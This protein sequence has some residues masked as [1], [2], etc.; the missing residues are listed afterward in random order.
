M[1][2][3]KEPGEAAKFECACDCGGE[4]IL[5]GKKLSGRRSVKSCGC[6]FVKCTTPRPIAEGYEISPEGCWNWTGR[7]NW[8]GYG[9]RG[10]KKAHR[11]VYEELV[12][13]IPSGMDVHHKCE[14]KR[15]VNPEHLEPLN[16]RDH[17]MRHNPIQVGVTILRCKVG[18]ALTPDNIVV[19]GVKR[20]KISREC[21]ACRNKT[22]REYWHT[23]VRGPWKGKQ[24][25]RRVL[26]LDQMRSQALF[27]APTT[28]AT[29]GA[30][31][32]M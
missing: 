15:C 18:H 27:T 21:R 4:I 16:P 17:Q 12:G 26:N 32:P 28:P 5:P 14:N 30:G 25:D 7:L 3:I 6:L 24:R 9:V 1:R 29:A 10:G 22:A 20:G 11:A 8:C 13:P 31:T 19:R 2:R 23:H